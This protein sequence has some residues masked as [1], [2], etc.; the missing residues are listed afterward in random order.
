MP[1]SQA[2][3]STARTWLGTPFRHQARIKH[4]GI[5]CFGFIMGVARELDLRDKHGAPA[6]SHDETTYNRMPSGTFVLRKLES[7][8]DEVAI[9][10]AKPGDLAL[11]TVAGNPQHLG[12][13]TDWNGGLG[14]IHCDSRSEYVV[15]HELDESWRLKFTRAFK[16]DS[17]Q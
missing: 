10:D 17:F 5:D 12:I 3:I 4:R 1:T 14:L 11:F 15:E 13:L 8:F 7:M 16:W 2:I 9:K 6:A